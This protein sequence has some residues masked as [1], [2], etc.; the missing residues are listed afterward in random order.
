MPYWGSRSDESDF[1]FDSVGSYI[2]LIKARMMTDIDT[3]LKK[4]YPEQGT[5]AS[6]ACLRLLGERFP[7]SL[8][9]HFRKKDFAFVRGAFEQWY[10]AVKSQLPSEHL[11]GILAEAEN[12][13]TLFEER[14]LAHKASTASAGSTDTNLAP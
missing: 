14:I 1:A 12:E 8:G 11:D 4:K 9:V 3:V 7:K 2:Y 13:F 5:I 6:L 10:A